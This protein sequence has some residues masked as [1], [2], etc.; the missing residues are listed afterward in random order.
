MDQVMCISWFCVC[1]DVVVGCGVCGMYSRMFE[2]ISFSFRKFGGFPGFSREGCHIC[3]WVGGGCILTVVLGSLMTVVCLWFS[4]ADQREGEGSLL[5]LVMFRQRLCAPLAP[6]W[7]RAVCGSSERCTS[8]CKECGVVHCVVNLRK[9]I[10]SCWFLSLMLGLER[11]SCI[12][13]SRI[14]NKV[15]LGRI[16]ACDSYTCILGENTPRRSTAT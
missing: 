6:W 12:P 5:L 4:K 15:L 14:N 13:G 8:Q 11:T 3:V 1:V 10:L 2:R 9:V 7:I 16:I